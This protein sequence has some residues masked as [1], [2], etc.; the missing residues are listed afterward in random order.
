MVGLLDTFDDTILGDSI[1]H[2]A[3]AG[4]LDRLVV[5][6]VHREGFHARDPVEEGIGDHPD[7]VPGLVARV[8]LAVRQAARYFVRNMLDQSAA[9]R[10]IEQLLTAANSEHRHVASE[11]PFGGGEFEGSPAIFG[12]DR[13]VP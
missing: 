2:E 10:D 9:E 3:R 4:D 5:C 1:D 12:F 7:E 8:R 13:W 11:C 6:A